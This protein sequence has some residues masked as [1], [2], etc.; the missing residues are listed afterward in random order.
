MHSTSNVYGDVCPGRCTG[1][2]TRFSP[3]HAVQ[4]GTMTGTPKG[5]LAIASMLGIMFLMLFSAGSVAAQGNPSVDDCYGRTQTMG[6][7]GSPGNSGPGSYR[8]AYFPLAFPNG[9]TVGCV[10][11]SVT[12]TSA[13]KVKQFLPC[14]GQP[15]VLTGGNQI[16]PNCQGNTL[17]GQVL[18]LSLSVGFDYY[19]PNFSS[20]P[21]S[22]GG[23][24]IGSGPFAGMSVADFLVIANDVLGG[25]S[26]AYSASAINSTAT[27]I[28]ENYVDGNSNGSFLYC[29]PCLVN[30]PPYGTGLAAYSVEC[31]EEIPVYA[32]VFTDPEGGPLTVEFQDAY[33]AF[34]CGGE[35]IRTWTATDDCDSTGTFVQTISIIDTTAPE[36]QNVPGD[37]TVSCANEVPAPANLTATD[38]C[39]G[40]VI[41][42]A[43]PE[44]T[45]GD[46]PCDYTIVRS[47]TATDV[48]GNVA[49]YT[50]NIHVVDLVAPVFTGGTD[51]ISVECSDEVPVTFAQASDNC[52]GEVTVTHEDTFFENGCESYI[53]RLFTATDECGNA[54]QAGQY[55]YIVD[56]TAPVFG[57]FQSELEVECGGLEDIQAPSATDNCS[58]IVVIDF[59]DELNSGGC[60]GVVERTWTATDECGNVGIAYQYISIVDNTAPVINTPADMAVECDDV[61]AMPEVTASDNCGYVVMVTGTEE[62]VPGDC[63]DSYTILWHWTAT[64]FCDNVA[65]STTTITVT[66]TTNPYWVSVPADFTV[67]C[68][69]ELPATEFPVA[70]DNCDEEVEVALTEED[71]LAG[72]CPN[73]YTIVRVFRGFDNC[74]NQILHTQEIHVTDTQAPVFA[75]QENYF[76]YQCNEETPFV[77]PV[78]SDN[79]SE[80][81]ELTYNDGSVSGSAC[82]EF[83]YR[84]WTA[85]DECGNSA[86]FVQ[87]L[88]RVDSE[89]P[90]FAGE[91]EIELPCD[92]SEG[93]FVTAADNC[94]EE[95]VITYEDLQVSGGCQGRIIRTYTATDDCDNSASFVQIITLTDETAPAASGV[96]E[97]FTVECGDEYEVSAPSF[98]DNCDDELWIESWSESAS[99]DCAEVVTY[100]WSA[101]DNCENVTVVSTTVTIVDTTAPA[102]SVPADYSASCDEELVFAGGSAYDVCA[103][104]LEVSVSE[105]TVEGDCPQS[106]LIIRTFSAVDACG[107][108]ASAEQVITVSD[109]TAPVFGE[110]ESEFSYECDSEVSYIEPSVSDNCGEVEL[111]YSDE[112]NE[113]GS[114]CAG[115][116]IRTWTATDECGNSAQFVQTFHRVDTSAPVFAGEVEIELPC[117]ESEGVFVTVADNCDEEV[118]ISYEDVQVSGGCQGRIIRT[119][120]ATDDCDNSASFVQIITLT[121]ETAPVASGVQESFTVECGD[122]YEVSAP[123]FS[124]NC[125]DELWIE[126]W[127]E[128]AN[129]DCAEVVTYYW[130]AEDNCENV[131][132]VSTT[133]TIVDTTAPALSVPADYSASCDE[134]LVFAGGSAYDVCAGDL[135]VSVSESTVE[136][137]CPQS[138]QIIRTFSAVD[139]CGNSAS[140]EQVITVSDTTAPVFG[141]Q[142][143]EF[144]YECDSE[145]SYIE[146]SVSDNCG[147]VELSYSDELNE[148]GSP[149]AGSVIRTW[150]AIDE[151]GNSAQFVQT[152]HRVDTSAPVFAGEVEIELPCDE[153]EGVFVT[154]AD[155]CD[156]E[157]A[158][159]Y[160]DVQV[161]GGC[162]G[163]IIRTYTATDDCDNSASFVQIITLTD[164]TAPAASGVQESFTV[165]CG[166]EYE[167]SAPSFSDNC[168]DELWIESWSES[169]NVDCAEVVTYYWSAEDNCENVTVVSTT[170]TIVDTTAPALSV[171]A[172]YSASCDEELVF[173]GGSAYDVCAGDL[174]VSVSESTVEG[175]CPQSYQIIRTFSAVDACGNSS[176]AEQVIT[177]SDTTAPVFGEQESE[178]SYECD[179]EVSYIE[180]SVSDNCGEVELSYSDELNEEGSACAGSV[181]RTWTATDECGNSA[182]FVQTFHRV[183]TSAPV[184]A[185]EV[186]IELPCDESEGVFVTAADNCD[187]EVAISYEDVQVSGGCQGRIIRTYT[188][189]DDCDNSASFVQ[190]IT[191]TDETAPVASGVQESFEVNCDETYDVAAPS[192]TDNCD[193]ELWIES[194]NES[195][196]EG[197][198]QVIT[199]YW[200]AEDNCENVTVVSTSVTITD[201]SAPE[202]TFVPENISASCEDV[203]QLGSAT[204][205]DNCDEMVTVSVSEEIV[206][207]DCPNAYTLIRTFTAT[208]DC[209]N[210]ATAVQTVEVSD[211]EA[212]EFTFVPEGG[213]FS[214]EEEIGFVAATAEDNCG[215]AAV[216]FSDA[217]EEVCANS[218]VLTRTWTATDAC[219][220]SATAATTYF[221]F[222]NI[223][224]EF[225]QELVDVFV[226]CANE[227]P[228]PVA[229]TATDNCG[230]A[231]VAVSTE[232]IESDD[233]GNQLILVSYVASDECENISEASY[234]IHVLDQTAPVLSEEPA[235]VQ[236]EC[237]AEWPAAPQITAQD[238]CGGLLEVSF[239]EYFIGDDIPADGAVSECSILTPV[240]P[241][242]NPCNYPVD[243]AMA[244]FG[245]PASHRYYQVSEGEFIQYPNGTIRVIATMHNAFNPS[246]GF[247]VDV[248]FVNGLDW[249]GWTSQNFLTG[250][251]ADCGGVAANKT[252]WMYYLLNNNDAVLTGF[253]GYAG[254]TLNLAH[255]PSNNYFGFQLGD[256]AN[257]YNAADNGF[258]GWFSY[259]GLFLVNGQQVMAGNA[260]GAG[261]FAFELDCCP[262]YSLV[263]CWTAMDCSGNV[264]QHC[265]TISYAPASPEFQGQTVDVTAA[266]EEAAKNFIAVFPNPAVEAATFSIRSTESGQASLEVLDVT[267]A[268]VAVLLN[269]RISAG[270]ELRVNFDVSD[271]ASGIYMYRFVQGETTEVGRVMVSK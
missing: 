269:G 118:A 73:E 144:S 169:A 44:V 3:N 178:F 36:F 185:G 255:A 243:W 68:S 71:I 77:T 88:A 209:G 204:A 217:T 181:I 207:G 233:C 8:D 237:G 174:E 34:E 53:L 222:D 232:V 22:L 133:V 63:A 136:G 69:D 33:T 25:C 66:D 102:L 99:V 82:E 271:L 251:K 165:E 142:E 139:A 86:Q 196:S 223:A 127:S 16:D 14:G 241:A 93:V 224:P 146:P 96:Q 157:V 173:A 177:V 252:Q 208:D 101:E 122:E 46:M 193:N 257:N 35:I 154:A 80:E 115:S 235:D 87:T 187:E 266:Q 116:V 140:A 98:S 74:G 19:D 153:S 236:I 64:D 151:C 65:T 15:Q 265:Q 261:D 121:D 184:F 126:S 72:D 249:N 186:E 250:F 59:T 95:V 188:A 54:S 58:E 20:S 161:S 90:V 180:P 213:Y 256:G 149:C 109:T 262:D 189:T 4:A 194:W 70:A 260:V 7:W 167:V 175:D 39:E 52:G 219:G 206:D 60:P 21:Y 201:S 100:Y 106:Y 203:L 10:Q 210:S 263:R 131:T 17:L 130:S 148:E 171:P 29:D 190:I 212:P 216:I 247:H 83:I 152:F 225:D 229:V 191:L 164:E 32:P 38:N 103:G 200:S 28:N 114:A 205:E 150:T 168:D 166:D 244:L 79:C 267:G 23:Q 110:Q 270:Q 43:L 129:V 239:E 192:F 138:Y 31:D 111:S 218:Y 62:I 145:V 128:S 37:V 137:D 12:L 160:E 211:S 105:S 246:N 231:E 94:D 48:C 158:I 248:E 135:E 195:A 197:C 81:V 84:T 182:Q 78:V 41:I 50:Q 97:S 89:A 11:N 238:N 221:V 163:R 227:I 27:A 226:E 125:D 51:P 61:P 92:E 220:N 170:V 26:N 214:C 124:D 85:I 215:D 104:D 55:I 56:T 24:L 264:T 117:D 143:S 57:E 120:T 18:A 30:L 202:F 113:E 253:G 155:N 198:T 76:A 123:S 1:Q 156:E 108:S 183:D 147:E 42:I 2:P 245:M 179:S 134:E 254:S 234:Y 40:T 258:G 242:G 6:G 199:Y 112:L 47:W 67:E 230:T 119:Y 176:S 162:Q 159:S 172:D 141:E 13:N 132:V 240:L 259:S 268:K 5:G 228:A 107:N 91:V 75:Q 9:V 49:T 45:E